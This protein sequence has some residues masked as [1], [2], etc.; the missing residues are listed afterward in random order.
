VLGGF[1]AGAPHLI[2]WLQNRGR[3]YLFSTSAPPSVVAA[4]MAALDVMHDEPDR[5]E[6]LWSNTAMFKEGLH[7]L[8]FD[9]G[10][11]QTPITPVITGDES[12]TQ[13]FARQLFEEGVFSPAI[14]FPTVAK[15]QARVR[16]IV[17]ADHTEADLTEAL[18]VFG[19]VGSAL[20]LSSSGAA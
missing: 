6:R 9:T 12:V 11:S 5:L 3:P 17:T 1:I 13:T 19:R 15:G 4:C 20:G 2:G 16:T 8:G 7:A 14:V 18:E 10:M